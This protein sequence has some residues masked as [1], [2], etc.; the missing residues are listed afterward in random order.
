MLLA[1]CGCI[2]DRDPG[3]TAVS[4]CACVE[5]RPECGGQV[6]CRA[7]TDPAQLHDAW[8]GCYGSELA[9]GPLEPGGTCRIEDFAPRLTVALP[10]APQ[11]GPRTRGEEAESSAHKSEVLA[12]HVKLIPTLVEK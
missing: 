3:I 12:D 10:L 9:A 11:G 4:W 7:L 2:V 1:G 8:W 6:D 5:L